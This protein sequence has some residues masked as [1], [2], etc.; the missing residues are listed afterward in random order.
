MQLYV[1]HK[2]S[3]TGAVRGRKQERRDVQCDTVVALASSCKSIDLTGDE[4]MALATR[5]L[6]RE[7]VVERH[8]LLLLVSVCNHC[9]SIATRW[10]RGR[11]QLDGEGHAALRRHGPERLVN[12]GV[13]RDAGLH[14]LQ[15]PPVLELA[16]QQDLI[17]A[18]GQ[19]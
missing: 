19:L 1:A 2:Y 14:S 8:R 11:F 9:S 15:S 18:V 17:K 7:I 6:E 5:V 16:G 4:F 10:I 3:A 13:E 12:L